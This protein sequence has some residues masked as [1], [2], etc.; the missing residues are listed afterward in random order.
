MPV[1]ALGD[2]TPKLPASGNCFIAPSADVIGLV[3]LR[4]GASVWF[5]CTLRGDNDWIVLGE[6]VN[7]QDNTVCHTDQGYP[8]E[9]ARGVTVGH[10]VTLHSCK[11][12][13]Y[14]L[15]GMGATL[16][17]GSVIGTNCLIAAGA[18]IKEGQEIPDN[19]LVVGAPGKV[20]R[21]LDDKA[22]AMMRKS[23]EGY[24][25]NGQRS[26]EQLREL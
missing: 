22:A 23:A 18:L 3:E 1:Y 7:I 4:E 19:S 6:D 12:G 9:L 20:V 13:E 5:N 21:Q 14:S 15:I 10:S 16:L 17:S 24:R 2:K 25:M 11:V 26:R 8:I